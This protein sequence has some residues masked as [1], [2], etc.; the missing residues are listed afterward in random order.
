MGTTPRALGCWAQDYLVRQNLWKPEQGPR[1]GRRDVLLSLLVGR[2]LSQ[3]ACSQSTLLS[4]LADCPCLACRALIK[5]LIY[6]EKEG[7]KSQT[8]C[9]TPPLP[10]P[11][12]PSHPPPLWWVISAGSLQR[13]GIYSETAPGR[14]LPGRRN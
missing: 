11:L 9:H 6:L 10:H 1:A 14:V 3:S 13:C 4:E 5:T 2:K 7:G 8:H 12:L